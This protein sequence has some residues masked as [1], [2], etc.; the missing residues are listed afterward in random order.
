[1]IFQEVNNSER[2]FISRVTFDGDWRGTNNWVNSLAVPK[3]A[4][5]YVSLVEDA[6]RYYIHY[7]TFHAADWCAG[8]GPWGVCAIG[9]DEH[10]NDMEGVK[11]VVDKRFTTA[12]YPFG[13][14]LTAETIFHTEI[15]PYQNCNLVGGYPMYMQPHLSLNGGAWRG[16]IPFVTGYGTAIP[17]PPSRPG[18]YI[19]P[20]GHGNKMEAAFS[21]H[22][23]IYWP[24]NNVPE[25]PTTTTA[26]EDI[27]YKLQWMDK[28]EPTLSG[29]SLWSLRLALPIFPNY[30]IYITDDANTIGP[31]DVYYLNSFVCSEHCPT[32]HSG[33]AKT[34]WGIVSGDMPGEHRGDWHNHPSWVWGHHFVAALPVSPY[35]D[36]TC[37]VESCR[38]TNTYSYNPFWADSY[39]IAGS[40]GGGTPPCKTPPCPPTAPAHL[41]TSERYPVE[42]RWDFITLQ[43]VQVV[44]QHVS[45]VSTHTVDDP[46]W[47]YKGG[48]SVLR[49]A[50]QGVVT[51]GLANAR[52]EAS[53]E[54]ALVRMR[55][56]GVSGQPQ[57]PTFRL[58]RDASADSG[59]SVVT[60]DVLS[61]SSSGWEVIRF[62][63][64]R[65][66]GRRRGVAEIQLDLGVNQQTV[67]LDFVLLAR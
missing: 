12:T 44:G 55:T 16:C 19:Q 31:H 58:G 24:S 50:G 26:T 43:D 45:G 7:G 6:N 10:E 9:E 66:I 53:D 25:T 60:S 23:I 17:A 39:W 18:L 11:F 37:L 57:R 42:Q 38:M 52:A 64:L 34:P 33:N 67:E 41:A 30:N 1:M 49:I 4:F 21:S 63:L 5:V 65:D 14:I 3:P 28:G 56:V 47:G 51:V 59:Q 54:F 8:P 15:L 22:G 27:A 35:Y 36:Y 13:Q 62:N 48:A 32:F 20:Q 29:S 61:R 2:D 46:D 40:G